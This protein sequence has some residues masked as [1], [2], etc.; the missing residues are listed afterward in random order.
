LV[1]KIGFGGSGYWLRK[2]AVLKSAQRPESAPRILGQ[3]SQTL[4]LED[5]PFS[6]TFNA[7]ASL[8]NLNTESEGVTI[9][10]T[11][12]KVKKNCILPT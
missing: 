3:D 2:D 9:I 11:C 1:V 8:H 10:T 6:V 12:L 7:K 4:G 5:L